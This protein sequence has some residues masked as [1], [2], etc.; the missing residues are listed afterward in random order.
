MLV[1]V[2]G[3]KEIILKKRAAVAAVVI[4]AVALAGCTPGSRVAEGSTVTVAVAEAFTSFNAATGFG[5]AVGTNASVVAATNSS[6]VS[7]DENGDPVP[8]ESFGTIVKVSD[9]PLRVRYTIADGVR[10]SDGVEVDAADL[11]LSWAA[12][13]RAL[14]TAGFDAEAHLDV[15]TGMFDDTIPDD[16]V[17]FDGFT[18]NGLDRVTEVPEVSDDG[19]SLTLTFDEFVADWQLVFSVGLPAHVVADV[20]GQGSEAGAA[21]GADAGSLKQSVAQAIAT[22]DAT[23]LAPLSRAWTS[24]FTVAADSDPARFVGSGPY[25]IA[26][27]G[28]DGLTLAVN[29]E[30]QGDHLPQFETIEVRYISDPLQAV[31]SASAGELDVLAPQS[32]PDVV[33]AIDASGLASSRVTT[34]TG[35]VLQLRLERSANGAVE[36]PLVRQAFLASVPKDRL[37]QGADDAGNAVVSRDSFTLFP[38]Q[39]GYDDAVEATAASRKHLT[40]RAP[41]ELIAAAAAENPALGAPTICVLFDPANPR[42]LAQFMAIRDA[43]APAG[44]AVTDCSS[45]DWRNLLATPDSWDAALFGLRSTSTSVQS[46]TQALCTGAPLNYGRYSSEAVD[47]ILQRFE[48]TDDAADRAGMLADVDEH[49]WRD[50]VGLPLFQLTSIVVTSDR[51][52]GVSVAPYAPTVLWNPWEWMPRSSV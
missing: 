24:G 26:A 49:L 13:S 14:N 8:D 2:H 18:S 41:A 23:A 45:P 17:F 30:Y 22:R 52:D 29:R 25:S 19:R 44:I 42:R 16:V 39:T 7:W 37:I 12:N 15:Q 3:E 9:D 46:A 31:A 40:S 4:A 50:A 34:G 20:A 48:L 35:E 28:D 5:S 47:G 33:A 32:S 38:G 36:H 1:D 11:L 43:A 10:W 51:I 21:G 27:I 6:F